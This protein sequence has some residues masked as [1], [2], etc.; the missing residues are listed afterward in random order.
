MKGLS[1]EQLTGVVS[2]TKGIYHEMLFVE[3]HNSTASEVSAHLMEATNFPGADVQF[4]MDGELI[5]EVQLKAISSPALVYEHLQRY[6]DVEIL[7][8]EEVASIL[9]GINSSGLKNAV[10]SKDV[11]DRLHELKG[12]GLFDEVSDGIITSAFVTSGV[13]VWG[14]FRNRGEQPID[15]KPY[16]ANAGIAAGTA[17]LIDGA[18]AFA[19]S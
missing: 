16:L 9:E 13:L 2:N 7:V 12:E 4:L 5:R 10:L 6:P 3:T 18:I 11:A 14:V 19:S 1:P 8:T 15:F 17:T